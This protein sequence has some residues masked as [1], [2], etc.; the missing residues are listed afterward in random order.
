MNIFMS[1]KEAKRR[2]D[3]FDP[4][5]SKCP[6]CKREFRTGCKHNTVEARTR[7]N[8]IYLRAIAREEKTS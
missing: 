1:A 3:E 7:L 2:M 6:I 8:E 4:K 5:G